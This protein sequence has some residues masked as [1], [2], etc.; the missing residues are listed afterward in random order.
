MGQTIL[1]YLEAKGVADAIAENMT[2]TFAFAW[3][4]Q[5]SADGATEDDKANPAGPQLSLSYRSV[6]MEKLELSVK[7][8]NYA[9]VV[10]ALCWMFEEKLRLYA[11]R[12]IEKHLDEHM[13]GLT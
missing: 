11:C 12:K 9:T 3:Q 8:T 10:N 6:V 5:P 4:Q 13:G 2:V 1:P 7:E